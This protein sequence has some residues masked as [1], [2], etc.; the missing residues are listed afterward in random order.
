MLNYEFPPI[1]GGGGVISKNISE[2]LAARGHEVVVLTT[3]FAGLS[4]TENSR[5]ITIVRLKS[6][7]K[8]DFQSNPL[9]M[10][11]WISS[12]K[13]FIK[14]W[15]SMPSF[16]LVFANFVRPGGD[17]ALFI[18]QKFKIPFVV[19]SHGH[20]IPWVHPKQMLGF[21]LISFFKI[22]SILRE[23]KL[24][25]VQSQKMLNN[26]ERF[27]GKNPKNKCISNGFDPNIFYPEA[28]QKDKIAIVFSGRLVLQ[29]DPFTF[30]RALQLISQKDT[31]KLVIHIFGDGDLRQKINSFC[32]EKLSHLSIQMHGKVAQSIMAEQMRKSPLFVLSSLNEGMPLNLIEAIA[33][34]C[35]V[36]YTPVSGTEEIVMDNTLGTVFDFGDFKALAKV[37]EQ[38]IEDTQSPNQIEN[39]ATAKDF[40]AKFSWS[41]IG[42]QYHQQ[43]SAL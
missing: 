13:R 7:R 2:Q 15:P 30:L 32:K 17:V 29:K 39:Q 38:F 35:N 6:L 11:S 33:C 19:I 31:N 43:I 25:F 21:H 20:D 18:K 24:N 40:V 8:K 26:L 4:E 1:G 34:G 36:I 27:F 22:K 14:Q 5:N 28:K 9:E 23:S 3:W 16:N 42:E 37:I 12:C 41:A 10:L